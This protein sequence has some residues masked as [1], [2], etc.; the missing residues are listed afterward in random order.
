[1][2]DP[3]TNKFPYP[4]DTDKHYLVVK[5]NRGIVF[6]ENYPYID[7]SK[8]FLRKYNS[9]RFLTRLIGYPVIAIRFA[10]KVKGKKNLK[11]HEE[12]LK[13][14][15]V[16]VCNHVNMC[17]FIPITSILHKYK[18]MF[19]SWG[20]NVNGENGKMIRKLGG[21]PIPDQS[22]RAKTV[23]FKEIIDHIKNGGA[24]HLYPEGSMWEFYQ[25]IR[26]LKD[27]AAYFSIKSGRPIL[28]MAYS[29]RKNGFIRSKIFKSIAKFTLNIGE[30]IYPDLTLPLKEAEEKL[31]IEVH[32]AM[33][34]LAG[35]DP[36]E[37]IYP[38]IYNNSKRIDYYTD[39]Y[40]VGYKK[41]W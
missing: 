3:K 28:P 20:P 27:G 24:F 4:I 35:I 9:F 1:M 31:T 14:G 12:E 11:K 33:C 7:T 34:R 29:Y 17:D 23:C 25:P 22:F 2:F 18:L 37:N 41:S 16:N 38:P 36:K 5:E 40:G 32:E 39:T 15:F 8:E 19:L 10:L 30:P 26:P 6:D 21:A 13:K